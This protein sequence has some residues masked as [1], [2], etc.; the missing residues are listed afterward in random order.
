MEAVDSLI[1]G[2]YVVTMDAAGREFRGG[3][4][5]IRQGRLVA[6]GDSA[7]VCARFQAAETIEASGRC[8]FPGLV[9]TH[10]HLFQTFM[11]GL[12]EGLHVHEWLKLVT[13]PGFLRMEPEDFYLSAM[14]GCLEAIRSGT[15]TLVEYM[16]PNPRHEMGDAVLEALVDSGVRALLGRSVADIG[17]NAG[18]PVTAYYADLL[19]PLDQALED[20]ARLARACRE[21]GQGRVAFCLAPPNLRCVQPQTFGVFQDF[22]R[23][24]GC[25]ITMHTCETPR[26]DEII[27]QRHGKLAIEWLDGLGFLGPN[28]L[29][30]H[31][32]HLVEDG[33]RRFAEH[34]VKVSYN[35][36]SNMYLGNG[37]A[38]VSRMLQAGITV[39]LGVDG[40]ASNNSQNILEALKT[41]VLLQRA[42][43]RD[44]AVLSSRDALRLA[45]IDGARAIGL[46]DEI[47]SLEPGKRADVLIAD[48]NTPAAAP[49][50]NPVSTLVFSSNP[51]V[52][53][54]V[55]I[56]GR[57]V[58][59]GGRFPRLDEAGLARRAQ[60]AGHR[61]AL[62]SYG[63]QVLATCPAIAPAY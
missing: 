53:D 43:A 15:T 50:Y 18:Y 60:D 28:L 27:P 17:D 30:V 14:A 44:P 2:G 6:V 36:V 5:A 62:R 25:L 58:L 55:L 42:A 52:V 24:H 31:C 59:Q 51:Q 46:G 35:P 1:R 26:D 21:R 7:E 3:A 32:V 34:G 10:T 61:L 9:D 19:E 49:Y 20:C 12:G 33:I 11:K 54:T 29:A 45:T 23:Q 63:P 57:V 13:T 40:A 41:G 39:G 38:P 16:Y 37:V 22:A 48:F 8:I 56:D 4:L 47:G